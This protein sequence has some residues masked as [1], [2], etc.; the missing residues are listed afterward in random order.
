MRKKEY[1]NNN[2]TEITEERKAYL[3]SVYLQFSDRSGWIYVAKN[4]LI[5]SEQ[6]VAYLEQ[7]DS[8]MTQHDRKLSQW[9]RSIQKELDLDIFLCDTNSEKMRRLA[10]DISNI[11]SIYESM[12]ERDES[13]ASRRL[14]IETSRLRERERMF[15]TISYRELFKNTPIKN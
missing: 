1:M 2:Y 11:Y 9:T 3:D 13:Y 6:D 10:V 5:L 7:L 8:I 4:I 14:F 15:K 12:T